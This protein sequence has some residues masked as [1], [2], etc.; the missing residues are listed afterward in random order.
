[1]AEKKYKKPPLGVMPEKQ[2]LV[3][4]WSNLTDTIN[5]YRADGW[6]PKQEWVDERRRIEKRIAEINKE[7]QQNH[8]T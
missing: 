7:E 1:M 3:Q 6:D 5:R 4:R 2:W 8:G